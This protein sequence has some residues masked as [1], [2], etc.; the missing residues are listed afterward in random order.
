MSTL[1]YYIIAKQNPQEVVMK[2]N[3]VILKWNPAISSVIG[4]MLK[5]SE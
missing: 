4:V 5:Q 3:Y 1:L 2:K